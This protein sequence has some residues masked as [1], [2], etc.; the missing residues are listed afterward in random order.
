MCRTTVIRIIVRES[1]QQAQEQAGPQVQ[2]EVLQV[3]EEVL[4]V[5]EEVEVLQV[6]EE[7]E[8][9]QVQEEAGLQESVQKHR[10]PY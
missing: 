4:Q 9:L 2:E 10:G 3:Q 5:Q 1:M 8:V 7:V 6:Q